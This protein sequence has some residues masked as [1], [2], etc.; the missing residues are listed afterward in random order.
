MSP[1]SRRQHQRICGCNK[2][3]AHHDSHPDG[4]TTICPEIIDI[5]IDFLHDDKHTLQ[6][7]AL[8]SKSWLPASRYHLTR[9]ITVDSRN[10]CTFRRL[11]CCRHSTLPSSILHLQVGLSR[12]PFWTPPVN[13]IPH[14][15]ALRSLT[16]ICKLQ[17]N[18]LPRSLDGFKTITILKLSCISIPTCGTLLRILAATPLLETVTLLDIKWSTIGHV[19]DP[20][21]FPYLHTLST[22]CETSS[23][24]LDWLSKR[25]LPALISVSIR[26]DSG[27]ARSQFLRT[28]GSSL[29]HLQVKM[30]VGG[31]HRCHFGNADEVIFFNSV[32]L[33]TNTTL[34]SITIDSLSL[35][36]GH[37]KVDACFLPLLSML[38]R[39]N[40]SCL[41]TISLTLTSNPYHVDVTKV[42]WT[43]LA[44][45]VIT[46]LNSLRSLNIILPGIFLSPRKRRTLNFEVERR[47]CLMKNM[48]QEITGKLSDIR[49]GEKPLLAITN[50]SFPP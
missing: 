18:T 48:E 26:A 36:T 2:P 38:F 3:P 8:V 37:F 5:I 41:D 45:S 17:H 27:I 47:D 6:T 12:Y 7:C 9:S 23:H 1:T 35:P 21:S 40:S 46:H 30:F 10:A 43:Q 28:L 16:L 50:I 15:R 34:R 25:P 42:P 22:H 32:D 19:P 33:S 13:F 24:I 4:A 39:I 44:Q 49:L 31:V 20:Q 29:Q 14:L 11:L